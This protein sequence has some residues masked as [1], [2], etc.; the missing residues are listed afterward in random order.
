MLKWIVSGD[1]H[2]SLYRFN[3]LS[4]TEKTNILI[5]GDAGFNFYLNKTDTKLKQAAS[6]L[7]VNF[8]CVRGNHE[9]RPEL[10]PTMELVWDNEVFGNVY[11]ENDFPNIKYLQDGK[12]YHFGSKRALV[13]GG[14]YSVDKYYRLR[15]AGLSADDP[16]EL[17]MKRAGWFP[18]EQ[19]TASEMN[20]ISEH[21]PDIFVD[22]VVSH[23][24]PYSWQ[25]TDL[26]LNGLDQSTVDNTMEHWLDTIKDKF[27]WN[28]WLF[29]HFHDDR[30][31]RPHVEM[32]YTDIEDL[33][34]IWNRWNNDKTIENEWWLK[35]S[36]DY[37]FD[38]N[39]WASKG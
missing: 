8:Y 31:V 35:K 27:N 17:I 12:V 15:R 23:T 34:T 2:G 30:L 24:C 21:M 38:D 19:L 14:A 32:Y 6:M 1:L 3:D 37:Y 11:V 18:A 28:I 20:T 33:D 4:L 25:P 10:I 36:P 22:F 13:L 39:I 9:Q 26:F 5:L 7:N 29:G 16:E